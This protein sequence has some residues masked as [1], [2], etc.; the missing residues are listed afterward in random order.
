MNTPIS[1]ITPTTKIIYSCP[2]C[3]YQ[4]VKSPDCQHS[5]AKC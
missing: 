3:C 5:Y 2:P 1:A 4:G